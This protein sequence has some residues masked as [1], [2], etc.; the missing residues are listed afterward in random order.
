MHG[1]QCPSCP[2]HIENVLEQFGS[3]IRMGLF[4]ADGKG[5]HPVC[6][7]HGPRHGR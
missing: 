2:L 1:G 5:C 6:H 4:M 3:S 7:Y